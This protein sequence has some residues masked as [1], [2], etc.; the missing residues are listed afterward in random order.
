MKLEAGSRYPRLYRYSSFMLIIAEFSNDEHK[1]CCRDKRR[2]SRPKKTNT[3]SRSKNNPL[4][5][6]SLA[7]SVGLIILRSCVRSTQGA[8]F[9]HGRVSGF[10]DF[11]IPEGG[12]VYS[13]VV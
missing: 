8:F 5:Q 11:W 4:H 1:N 9:L 13:P 10:S 7:Q 12:T 6:A 2:L 3:L